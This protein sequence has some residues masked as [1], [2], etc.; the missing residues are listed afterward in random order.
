MSYDPQGHYDVLFADDKLGELR[1]GIYYEQG[2]EAG[3]LDGD[4]FWHNGKKA[5]HREGLEL[6][7][8]S[9]EPVTRFQLVPHVESSAV[10]EHMVGSTTLG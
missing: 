1:K 5:G 8:T 9:P 4:D 10:N 3:G 7:R 2:D 6:V